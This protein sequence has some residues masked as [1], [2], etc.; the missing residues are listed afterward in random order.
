MK[1]NL[2]FLMVIGIL[3]NAGSLMAGDGTS[4][5]VTNLTYDGTTYYYTA[6]VCLGIS[7]NWGETDQFSL[8]IVGACATGLTTTSLTSTYDYCTAT[9]AFNGQG[10]AITA[11]GAAPAGGTVQTANVNV[12]GS[13][14]GGGCSTTYNFSAAGSMPIGPD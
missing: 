12:S 10:C 2:T 3:L 6:E 1:R 5:A 11:M 4:I 14:G 9:L 8:E 13:V 7:P